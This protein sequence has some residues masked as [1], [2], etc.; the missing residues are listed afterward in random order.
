[1]RGGSAPRRSPR[2]Q[3][4]DGTAGAV[5][6][7]LDH[8][9]TLASLNHQ[10]MQ[11]LTGRELGDIA[12]EHVLDYALANPGSTPG[13]Y[14]RLADGSVAGAGKAGALSDLGWAG[15]DPASMNAATTQPV[16][17]IFG[18]IEQGW[19]TQDQADA[20]YI[21][22][23]RAARRMS[24]L[25]DARLSQALA[26]AGLDEHSIGKLTDRKNALPDQI[27]ELWNTVYAGKGWTPP[28]V[29]VAKLTRGLHS[30]F[31]EPEF[32]DHVAAAKSFGVPAFF[33]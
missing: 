31:S 26:G 28:E 6:P 11:L 27:Q 7:L 15:T 1:M 29:P 4:E 18:A 25:P 24:S 10:G 20:A 8:N 30:G 13:S 21:A 5:A 22:A 19:L 12:R 32:M 16:S 23:A 2:S 33:R 14:L 9:G 17:L 3:L